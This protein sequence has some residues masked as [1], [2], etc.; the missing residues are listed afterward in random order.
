MKYEEVMAQ[1]KS[2]GEPKNV[3][4]MKRF[5]IKSENNFGNSVTYLRNFA[6]KI[7][8]DHELAVKLWESGIRDAR[9]VAACI[10]NPETVSEE[11]VDKWVRDLDS[12]DICDHC[13]GHFFDKTPFAYK[14]VREWTKSNELFVKRAGFSLIAWLAV[15]DKK[16]D[17]FEFVDFLKIIERESTDERNYIRKSVNWALRQIGKRNIDMNKKALEL[18]RKIQKIDSKTAKWIASDAIRELTSEKVKQRLDKNKN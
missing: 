3:E 14:K 1:L 9:M 7:G 4:G 17:D 2:M 5:G 18:S 16:K 15:H 6:K 8:K 13:C 10:E 12:W 11:Q